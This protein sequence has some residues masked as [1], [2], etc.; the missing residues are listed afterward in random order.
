MVVTAVSPLS[1]YLQELVCVRS[2]AECAYASRP[3][4]SSSFLVLSPLFFSTL[5]SKAAI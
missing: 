1:E 5:Q 3:Q 2:M 4:I